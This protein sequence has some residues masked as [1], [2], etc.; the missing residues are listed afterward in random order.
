MNFPQQ[1]D[2]FLKLLNTTKSIRRE[3]AKVLPGVVSQS[4]IADQRVRPIT[5]LH[6]IG[7][8]IMAV[9][10]LF[11][12]GYFIAVAYSKKKTKKNEEKSS[13]SYSGCVCCVPDSRHT[14]RRQ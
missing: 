14:A 2:D 1:V 11:Y 6:M 12:I 10:V 5:K 3:I 8:T 7:S 4:D 9:L 13:T